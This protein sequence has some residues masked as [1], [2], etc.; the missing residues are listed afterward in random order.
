[1]LVLASCSSDEVEVL[2]DADGMYVYHVEL[3]GEAPGYDTATRAAKTW[4]NGDV[5]Y[6][7]FLNGSGSQ[8]T[9]GTATYDGSSWTLKT[10]Q[11]LSG[12]GS[13]WATQVVNPAGT[14]TSSSVPLNAQSAAYQAKDGTWSLSGNTL[15]VSAHLKPLLGRVRFK[16]S[17]GT[18]FSL[19]GLRTYTAFNPSDGTFT[20]SADVVSASIQSS[21]YSPYLYG[22]FANASSPSLTIGDYTLAGTSSMM[23]SGTSGW[24]NYP[25]ASN[26]TGWTTPGGG[27]TPPTGT[28]EKKTFTVGGVS[29]DMILVEHGTF[30]M[31]A[32]SEQQ[33]PDSEEKPAHQVT[34][35]KDYYMGETEVTQALWKAVTGYSPTSS[36]SSWSSSYGVGSMKMLRM[37]LENAILA[38]KN[39][40]VLRA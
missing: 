3:D 31:G 30:T 2:R 26:H 5:L 10:S 19:S 37:L 17:S 20:S 7:R 28:S 8:L 27:S 13:C 21:G 33:N 24:L 14:A 39:G 32:T 34:I 4:Q 23:Q 11:S 22:T 6:L 1:M 15:R 12:S 18:S 9:T 35:S 29:F 36:G 38:A 40:C 16:G 25:T